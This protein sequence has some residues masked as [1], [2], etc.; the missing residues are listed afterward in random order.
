[1]KVIKIII[2]ILLSLVII[3]GLFLTYNLFINPKSP[4]ASAEY[5]IDGKEIDI[6]YYRPYKKERLIF[7]EAAD[8]A[9][10]PYGI[11]WRLG[12][13]LTTKISTNQDLDF[14]GRILPMGTYGL[15]TYPYAENWVLVVHK[16]TGRIS[17]SEPD[18]N[19]IV[20]KINLP[21]QTLDESLEQFTIDFVESSIRIR[22]D[23]TKVVIPIN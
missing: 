8:S 22:W 18:S 19:G 15:Y 1:M 23:T 10:V 6:S 12:A 3:T 13:N 21:V 20:M 16:T 11:Y 17:F 14:A 4:Q 9:L 7:G 5:K 2:G